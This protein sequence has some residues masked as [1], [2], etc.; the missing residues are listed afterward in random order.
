[1]PSST[2]YWSKA[3]LA[4]ALRDSGMVTAVGG[5][6]QL[7]A[8]ERAHRRRQPTAATA[9]IKTTSLRLLVRFI[10]LVD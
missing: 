5:D 3:M 9:S 4:D 7:V 8:G 10:G 6:V 2:Y 1:M